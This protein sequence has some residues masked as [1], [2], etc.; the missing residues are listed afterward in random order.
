MVIF[1]FLLPLLALHVIDVAPPPP[2]FVLDAEFHA[3]A[4]KNL[5]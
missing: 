2:P 3:T 4:S 5:T 1:A